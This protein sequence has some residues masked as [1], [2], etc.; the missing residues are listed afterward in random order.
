MVPPDYRWRDRV[1][2]KRKKWWRALD[3]WGWAEN[4]RPGGWLL[5]WWVILNIFT[6]HTSS[7]HWSHLLLYPSSY[8]F[9]SSFVT[10]SEKKTYSSDNPYSDNQELSIIEKHLLTWNWIVNENY[11]HTFSLNSW[12]KK[13]V[14][15]ILGLLCNPLDVFIVGGFLTTEWFCFDRR[16]QVVV[17]LHY[18]EGP[19][20]RKRA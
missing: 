1:R 6:F 3:A 16:A 2:E 5:P 19:T 14:Y 18:P 15:H 13:V 11:R 4:I 7:S 12:M 8:F 17:L 9:D 20:R 10:Y